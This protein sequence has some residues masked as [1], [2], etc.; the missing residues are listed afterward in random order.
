MKVHIWSQEYT[1]RIERCNSY[2]LKFMPH[3]QNALHRQFNEYH[4]QLW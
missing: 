2:K 1:E 3:Y 4:L